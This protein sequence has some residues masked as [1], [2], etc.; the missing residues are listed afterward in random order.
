MLL[1]DPLR[2]DIYKLENK[3]KKGKESYIRFIDDILESK[4]LT[5]TLEIIKSSGLGVNLYDNK[6]Q[7]ELFDA[8]VDHLYRKIEIEDTVILEEFLTEIRHIKSVF[9]NFIEER[10]SFF[11]KHEKVSDKYK[12][13]SY[14]MS[15]ELHLYSLINK[16]TGFHDI[17]FFPENINDDEYL[18]SN[19]FDS[20][21]ES[22]GMILKS[23]MY[24]NNNFV[25]SKRN[26]S[27]NTLKYSSY[28][29]L[30]SEI[31]NRLNDV[32]E[33]WKYSDVNVELGENG[34][35][36]FNVMDKDFQYNN[37]ISNERFINLR[38]GWQMSRLG[39]MYDQIFSH[40]DIPEEHKKKI[41]SSL[42]YS[43][44]VLYFGSPSLDVEIKGIQLIKWLKAYELIIDECKKFLSKR[45]KIKAYNLS[46]VC[47]I[48]S[49]S[50]WRSLLTRNGFTE[51]ES[52][53]ILE[54]LTFDRKSQDLVDCPLVKVDDDLAVIPS[55][56]SNVDAA[57]ALASNF[58]NKGFNLNFRGTEFETRMKGILDEIGVK[59]NRLYKKIDG[60]E[61]ECDIAFIIDQELFFVECKAHV[62]PYTT[63]QHA[64]HLFKLYEETSQINRIA[65]FYEENLDLV[66]EQIGVEADF[67]PLKVHRILLTTSMIGSPL[68]I[69]GVYI[70]D[71][72]SLTKVLYREPPA[73]LYMENGVYK[74]EESGKFEIY[75]GN[76]T[77]KKLID[78]LKHPP[79]V[80]IAKELFD[81]KYISLG[82][83]D[84]LD[85]VKVN[86]TFH[87]GQPN[88]KLSNEESSLLDKYF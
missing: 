23:F 5:K 15:L 34:K 88:L 61:Y 45:K 65:D 87:A 54:V 31:W 36:L 44:A 64:N 30:Y 39:D 60:T 17:T 66:R 16:E 4:G 8:V 51:E 73:L 80:Q 48:K 63:R 59:N 18:M 3:L 53:I 70:T 83:F 62:Q 14:L 40:R 79:Q 47:I 28:H 74:K 33:Y 77:A 81:E 46:K 1:N 57:R 49:T 67:K 9:N 37:L 82:L 22:S 50:Q 20:A 86:N 25:G 72:S 41:H 69:N 21:I 24:N 2:F 55:L 6:N 19:F 13:I 32:L 7:K 71:E 38:E 35:A 52:K 56:T 68:F 76:L 12:V 78:F 42:N 58:L 84:I 43:F 29:V 26:I 85:I 10:D 27:P 11:D 75:K